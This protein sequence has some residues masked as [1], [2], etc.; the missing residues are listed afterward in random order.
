MEKFYAQIESKI[1]KFKEL[2]RGIETLTLTA[3]GSLVEE[4]IQ[5]EGSSI[6]KN[7]PIPLMKKDRSI[8]YYLSSKNHFVRDYPMR[9]RLDLLVENWDV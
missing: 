8:E 6:T 2:T 3:L 7:K 5:N 9:G 4:S 1:N